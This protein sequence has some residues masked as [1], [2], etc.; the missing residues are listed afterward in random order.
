MVSNGK[1][2]DGYGKYY[3][4]GVRCDCQE[5]NPVYAGNLEYI[6]VP[7]RD[8]F[9]YRKMRCDRCNNT[10]NIVSTYVP[11]EFFVRVEYDLNNIGIYD[12][13]KLPYFAGY[14]ISGVI[15]Y[16]R[17]TNHF[18]TIKCFGRDRT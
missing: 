1:I 15:Q 5:S 2:D 4:P 7:G 18:R 12:K 13:C 17:K 10:G 8:R 14:Y 9:Q 6:K 11:N 16:C 3:F